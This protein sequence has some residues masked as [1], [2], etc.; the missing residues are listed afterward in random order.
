MD[1]FNLIV[2]II[3][4]NLFNI[5][6]ALPGNNIFKNTKI[7]IQFT[8]LI[9]NLQINNFSVK[10]KVDPVK[11]LENPDLF[12]GDILGVKLR[13]NESVPVKNITFNLSI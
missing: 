4:A 13:V 12:G 5:I 7:N 2:L 1:K 11:A 3:I 6:E 8:K 9:F 10:H